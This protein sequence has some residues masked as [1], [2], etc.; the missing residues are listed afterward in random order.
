MKR[1]NQKDGIFFGLGTPET[2]SVTRYVFV[3]RL[4]TKNTCNQDSGLQVSV[5]LGQ[6]VGA[7]RTTRL[8]SQEARQ[9]NGWKE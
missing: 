8:S 7:T 1:L 5:D 9:G 3:R 6:G 2:L 4:R